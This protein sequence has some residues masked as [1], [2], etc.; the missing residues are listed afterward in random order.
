MKLLAA[1]VAISL[2]VACNNKSTVTCASVNAQCGQVMDGDGNTLDCG[3]CTAPATCGGGG[4]ANQC[5]C[6]PTTC[7]KEGRVC[8]QLADGCGAMLEC[9]SCTAPSVCSTGGAHP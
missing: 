7:A 1:V 4:V 6:T 5:G 3:A 9:G 2:L 8:G